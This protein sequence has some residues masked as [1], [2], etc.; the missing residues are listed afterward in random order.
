MFP[1]STTYQALV[2]AIIR[3]PRDV[4]NPEDLGPVRF[5]V[6]KKVWKRVDLTLKNQRDQKLCCSHFVPENIEE[7]GRKGEK[8]PVVVYLHGNS[9]SRIEAMGSLEVSYCCDVGA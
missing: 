4:Y 6:G 1:W 7:L 8:W 9:S 3:P 5:R 2:D